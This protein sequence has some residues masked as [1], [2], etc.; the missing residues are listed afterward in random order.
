MLLWHDSWAFDKVWLWHRLMTFLLLHSSLLLISTSQRSRSPLLLPGG[1]EG[2]R[3]HS[4][5]PTILRTARR[6]PHPRHRST[7]SIDSVSCCVIV[8]GL[9][10]TLSSLHVLLYTYLKWVFVIV[11]VWRMCL[12]LRELPLQAIKEVHLLIILYE[13]FMYC[14]I[15][16][17]L[18]TCFLN[19]SCMKNCVQER[20]VWCV[21]TKTKLKY[22]YLIL[23]IISY[24]FIAVLVQHLSCLPAISF[25]IHI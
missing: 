20:S 5:S 22:K 4:S 11:C 12:W 6:G 21:E 17:T 1:E 14:P 7:V 25:F 10:M 9:S 3:S 23:L 2:A 15:I 16:H 18:Y 13:L 24:I 19:A 8:I